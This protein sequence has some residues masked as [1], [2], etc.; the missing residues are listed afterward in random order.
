MTQ[1]TMSRSY[2]AYYRV[3]T[4]R[5][6]ISGLG[7]DAQKTAV[8]RITLNG[9]VLAEFEEIESGK[10]N[11]RVVL[12]EAISTA[13]KLG[14]TLVIAKLDRLSRNA[15][16][17]FALRDSGVEFICADMPEA[18][19][20][21]IGIMAVMA[22]HEREIIS[23]RTKSALAELK[24]KGVSLGSPQNLTDL[25][26]ERSVSVRTTKR[27]EC[28]EWMRATALIQ[29]MKHNGTSLNTMA[30]TLNTSGYR[31]RQGKLFTAKT[32]SRLIQYARRKDK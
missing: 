12:Q 10:N 20:L 25:S 2:V 18:N 16:F 24:A 31:T 13:K 17:I 19:T 29:E 22:Q 32:V 23:Q 9:T 14:A 6:G 8:N 15:A 28:P 27:K 26:R 1:L 11:T 3:S 21:T 4:E 5:Q 30:V 7:L